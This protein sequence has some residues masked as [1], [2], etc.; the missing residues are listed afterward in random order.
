MHDYVVSYLCRRGAVKRR[1]Y[2]GEVRVII[3]D[4]LE[5]WIIKTNLDT[6]TTLYLKVTT[7][8]KVGR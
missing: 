3:H 1:F 6:F 5:Y 2:N 8:M 4:G 7:H